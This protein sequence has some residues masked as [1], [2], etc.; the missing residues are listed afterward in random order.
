MHKT[1]TILAAALIAF[2]V[3]AWGQK[4]DALTQLPPTQQQGQQQVQ[5]QSPQQ[6]QQQSPRQYQQQ[7]PQTQTRTPNPMGQQGQYPQTPVQSQEQRQALPPSVQYLKESTT[8]PYQS[9][10]KSV[11]ERHKKT[12]SGVRSLKKKNYSEAVTHFR[13]AIKADSNYAKAQYNA[14][15]AHGKL[16]QNDTALNYYSRVCEN[17]SATKEQRA[18]SHYNA[19]NIHLRKALATRDTGGYDP[20]SL[21]SAINEYKSTL[22]LDPKNSDAQH[23]LSLAKQLLRPEAQQ[24][25]GNGQNQQK[26]QDQQGQ[27]QQQQNQQNQDQQNQQNQQN[28]DQQKQ[29]QQNQNNSQQQEGQQGKQDKQQQEQRRR[30]AEQML[31]AMKNNEQQTMKAIR[32]KEAEKERRQGRPAKI[33]KDW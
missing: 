32:M 21:Q 3:N 16:Q 19:G 31:N 4:V 6:R 17:S 18:K 25:G 10:R 11:R 15:I 27:D 23:N 1:L 13:E 5:Q 20:Q 29:D 14:A 7:R 33:E 24:G 26:N 12:H 9:D 22:R 28:Q 8:V 30:E 2:N